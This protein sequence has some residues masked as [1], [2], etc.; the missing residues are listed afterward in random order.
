MTALRNFLIF[1][2]LAIGLVVASVTG[3]AAQNRFSPVIRVNDKVI[4]PFELEQRQLLLRALGAPGDLA[5]EARDRL[6]EERLQVQAAE[7]LGISVTEEGVQTGIAEFAG[8]ANTTPENFIATLARNGVSAEHFAD[9]VTAGLLWREV[10]RSRFASRAQVS[11]E[12]VDRAVALA[13]REGGARVLLS[14]IILPARNPQEAARSEALAQRLTNIN[15]TQ[16]FAA[17]A[18]QYSASP[19]RGRG[20]QIDWLPIGRLPPAIRGQLL[21]LP[22][23]GVTDPVRIPNAIGLFQLRALEEVPATAPEVISLDYA[24]FRIPGGSPSDARVIAGEIDTCDD[25][26][27]VAHKLPEDRLL[28]ET[29]TVAE[30]PADVRQALDRLDANE[31]DTSLRRGDVQLLVMLCGRTTAANEEVDRSAVRRQLLNQRLESY[32]AGYLA[33]LLADAVIVDLG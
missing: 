5:E 27:G 16:A 17:A 31:T 20:G 13:G 14:E 26:Y 32:A 29:R 11:E 23:G 7:S 2:V 6:I 15:G 19:S 33:E 24:E 21:T 8:R 4:T 9:F 12:E 3:A 25:L 22:P 30:I 10:V 18:R 28:R 1:G